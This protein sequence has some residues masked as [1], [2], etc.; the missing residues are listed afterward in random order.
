MRCVRKK[1][2]EEKEGSGDEGDDV[3]D[4]DAGSASDDASDG[5][6]ADGDSAANGAPTPLLSLSSQ[7][8]GC[9]EQY[10]NR[11]LSCISATLC[12]FSHPKSLPP[13]PQSHNGCL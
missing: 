2:E 11:P 12:N 3:A 5:E 6:A 4:S 9:I 1:E 10:E 7:T 8:D 13:Q